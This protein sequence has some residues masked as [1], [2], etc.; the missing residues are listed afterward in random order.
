MLVRFSN[1]LQHRVS[2]LTLA[3]Q[4][5]MQQSDYAADY[6]AIY[7][8]KVNQQRPVVEAILACDDSK[9]G[10][11]AGSKPELLAVLALSLPRGMIICNGYKRS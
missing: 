5:A 7:P 10:L 11:E 8:I 3:F 1:I 6:T 9:V 4:T 2:E